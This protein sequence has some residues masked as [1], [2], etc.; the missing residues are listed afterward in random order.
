MKRKMIPV[1]A[2]AL[3]ITAGGTMAA[4]SQLVLADETDTYEDRY[5]E[6]DDYD[7]WYGE[8]YDDCY[9]YCHGDCYDDYYD[10]Y[11]D[12]PYEYGSLY[13]EWDDLYFPEAGGADSRDTLTEEDLQKLVDDG[14]ITS[15][16]KDK[17]L[18]AYDK[19]KELEDQI[20]KEEESIAGIEGRISEARWIAF[21]ES[22]LDDG[23]NGEK[24]NLRRG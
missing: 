8:Y 13:D 3:M 17:L 1:L 4:G 9:G 7:D 2:A 19:I 23:D 10:H 15:E 20:A 24:T 5:G 11:Y 18:T 6:W 12:D 22:L 14:T 21:E 16:E